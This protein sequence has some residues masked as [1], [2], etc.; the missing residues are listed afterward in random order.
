MGRLHLQRVETGKRLQDIYG[1]TQDREKGCGFSFKNLCGIKLIHYT[2]NYNI[3]CTCI[4]GTI[5]NFINNEKLALT[6]MLL[7]I[8]TSVPSF[9][10]QV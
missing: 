4:N 2:H 6:H 5:F 3:M 1:L 7:A 9:D 10:L 8:S